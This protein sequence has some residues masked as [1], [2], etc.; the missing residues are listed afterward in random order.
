MS[1]SCF[2]DWPLPPTSD[3]YRLPWVSLDH[4]TPEHQGAG[5]ARGQRG[6]SDRIDQEAALA[7]EVLRRPR[8]IGDIQGGGDGRGGAAL[9]PGHQL[10]LPARFRRRAGGYGDLAQQL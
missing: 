4:P 10:V 8:D 2:V 9:E 5:M 1:D 6:P 7:L 3:L